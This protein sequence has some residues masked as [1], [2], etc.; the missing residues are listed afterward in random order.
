MSVLDLAPPLRFNV[1]LL[2]M[3]IA[4]V[5]AGGTGSHLLHNLVKIVLHARDRG[6]PPI[7]LVVIDGDA[8][9]RSNTRGRQ[10]F[11]GRD[12]GYNKAEV[13]AAR[14]NAAYGLTIVAVPEMATPDVL[15]A[16]APDGQRS[17]GVLVGC[18]DRPSGRRALH[19]ALRSG[20]WRIWLDCGNGK[21]GGQ[22]CWGTTARQKEMT[23][24]L[25]MPG[26]CTEVPGP[27]LQFP[28]LLT[29]GEET[30][31]VDCAQRV[32][33]GE[34]DLLINVQ[35]AAIAALY[36]QKL[37]IDRTIDHLHTQVALNPPMASTHMLTE[38]AIAR[39]AKVTPARLRGEQRRTL[40]RA[41]FLRQRQRRINRR[42][43]HQQ[44]HT[45]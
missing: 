21:D 10:F 3:V 35:M 17:V 22:V 39:L 7:K 2:P 33:W 23:G 42:I 6:L 20:A 15:R 24:A 13:L 1:P 9:E 38:G 43:T 11:T 8:V 31:T 41:R 34:Q 26:L 18:V 16:F 40:R 4:L 27:S 12:I 14:F 45:L 37:I 19:A 32:A 25:L 5:G 28:Q 36:L 29:L 30:P 44:G